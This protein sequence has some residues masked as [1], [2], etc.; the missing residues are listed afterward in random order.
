M[1]NKDEIMKTA[2]TYKTTAKYY[3]S[4]NKDLLK[5]DIDFYIDYANKINGKVLEL[6]CGTGRITIPIAMAGHQIWGLDVS[7]P[8]L[9]VFR[10]KAKKENKTTNENLQILNGDMRNF[11]LNQKFKLIF[12]PFR[13]FQ[14]LITEEGQQSCLKCCH[15]HLDDD[16]LFIV[17]VF[18]LLEGHLDESWV[19]PEKTDY[20]TTDDGIKIKRTHIR[21]RVDLENQVIYPKLIYYV[22]N[23]DG[24]TEKYYEHLAIKYYYVGQLKELLQKNGFEVI[25]EFGYYDKCSI[26]EGGE[27]IFV[28]KKN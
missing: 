15:E 19:Q 16:G 20:E 26:E 25:N 23:K 8:M 5:D 18:K 11:E 4:D 13:T 17:N 3:D 28:C 7:E 9:D 10:E 24:K 2:N 27:I 12:I 1:K 14:S 21:E 6:G 22:T